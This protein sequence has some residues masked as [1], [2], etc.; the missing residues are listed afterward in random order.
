M[1]LV[2]VLTMRNAGGHE[3]HIPLMTL[4]SHGIQKDVYVLYKFC[5]CFFCC[6]SGAA[7]L[8]DYDAHREIVYAIDFIRIVF[9]LSC[10]V[11]HCN[12]CGNTYQVKVY[13]KDQQTNIFLGV[14]SE[15]YNGFHIC[16]Y[17]RV[18]AIF[19]LWYTENGMIENF[20]TE[21]SLVLLVVLISYKIQYLEDGILLPLSRGSWHLGKPSL[22]FWSIS[23]E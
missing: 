4:A 21:S 23:Q 3:I 17:R 11:I 16:Y 1:V 5:D 7:L 10:N 12:Y 13:N 14:S 2:L 6:W 8:W 15:K 20:I 9:G 19:W 22:T 18:I